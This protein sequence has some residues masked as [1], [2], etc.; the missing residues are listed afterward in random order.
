[1]DIDELLDP[2]N[3]GLGLRA[4]DRRFRF[5]NC[6]STRRPLRFASINHPYF[7]KHSKPRN[8]N[9]PGQAI[10]SDAHDACNVTTRPLG[11]LLSQDT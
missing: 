10:D 1:M 9:V 11:A 4:T 3:T 7:G 5:R 8:R 2:T 6:M